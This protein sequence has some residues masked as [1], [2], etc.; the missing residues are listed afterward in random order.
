MTILDQPKTESL[1][2]RA[3]Q[4][5]P[6]NT[7]LHSA[8]QVIFAKEAG[9]ILVSSRGRLWL[10][11]LTGV[12]SAFALL[13]VANTELS[14]LDNAQVVYDMM[15]L[16]TA[17]GALLAL[18]AGVDAIAGERERGS[19]VP[20]LLA[21]ISRGG[22]VAGKLGAPL[23]A[24]AAM[25]VLALPYLWAVGSTGQNLFTGGLA[26]V[27]LGTPVVLGFGFLGLALGASLQSQRTAL[28]VSLIALT[29]SASPVLLGPSLRQSTIGR[30]F[31][32]VNPFSGAMNAYDAVVIDSQSLLSQGLHALPV[33]TF[34]ILTL[35]LARTSVKAIS[36]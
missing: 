9:E 18:L 28:S 25:L 33:I 4:G 23:A 36:R 26:L 3:D 30:V 11:L 17:L 14:L 27:L 12:L 15:G 34:L 29:L 1:A 24:W 5:A 10:L 16:I 20:L 8:A 6:A 13:F 7:R 35:W 19:L 2:R 21:P 31:D 32:A 22:L